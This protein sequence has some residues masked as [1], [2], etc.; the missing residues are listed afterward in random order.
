MN[1]E[2]VDP[3]LHGELKEYFHNDECNQFSINTIKFHDGQ[4]MNEEVGDLHLSEDGDSS[5]Q[6]VVHQHHHDNQHQPPFQP[7]L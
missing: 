5:N 2:D 4:P 1:I 7:Q 6:M 3:A